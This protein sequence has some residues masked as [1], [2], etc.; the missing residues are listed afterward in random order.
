MPDQQTNNGRILKNLASQIRVPGLH[1]WKK[2]TT[3]RIKK[4]PFANLTYDKS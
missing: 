1:G 2:G 4:Q 3:G